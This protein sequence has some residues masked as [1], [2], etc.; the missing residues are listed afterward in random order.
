[1]PMVRPRHAMRLKI[2]GRNNRP[3]LTVIRHDSGGD[4]SSRRRRSFGKALGDG[5]LRTSTIVRSEF[6]FAGLV[7]ATTVPL[8]E[9]GL[10]RGR[11]EMAEIGRA[12]VLNSSHIP[13][14]R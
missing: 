13:L 2:V 3:T 7:C 6:L 14:S 4:P 1:M 12:H 10:W 11:S 9:A 5:G 8:P